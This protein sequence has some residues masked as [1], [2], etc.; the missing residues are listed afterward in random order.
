[1]AILSRWSQCWSHL[2]M[3]K[4]GSAA[5]WQ[6]RSATVA[7]GPH[8]FSLWLYKHR[9][10]GFHSTK[11]AVDMSRQPLH[12]L[13]QWGLHRRKA[14]PL[15][16]R[17]H[18]MTSGFQPAK[19]TMD[20]EPWKPRTPKEPGGFRSRQSWST[21]RWSHFKSTRPRARTWPPGRR[22]ELRSLRSKWLLIFEMSTWQ[23]SA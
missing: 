13:D 9:R 4:R 8:A 6:P 10:R 18:Q 14:L 1:M 17:W 11:S 22:L 21:S 20:W 2:R 3:H 5:W 15:K 19:T 23:R 12:R 7:A 16:Q